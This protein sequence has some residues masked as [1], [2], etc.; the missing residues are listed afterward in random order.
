VVNSRLT[1]ST[2]SKPFSHRFPLAISPYSAR[3]SPFSRYPTIFARKKQISTKLRHNNNF[4]PPDQM[5]IEDKMTTFAHEPPTSTRSVSEEGK[6]SSDHDESPRSGRDCRGRFAQG[7]RPG[8]GRPPKKKR[9][10]AV[11]V[12]DIYR[13]TMQLEEAIAAWQSV[14]KRNG[15][16][17]A[18]QLLRNFEAEH[19]PIVYREIALEAIKAAEAGLESAGGR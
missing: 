7:C 3:L 15:P 10:H 13:G 16:A 4:R 8:P 14:V 1:V 18:R 19:G 17:H 2:V 9:S 6:T 12:G 5:T 11:S